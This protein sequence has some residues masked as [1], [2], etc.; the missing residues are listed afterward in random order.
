MSLPNNGTI[1]PSLPDFKIVPHS[2][3]ILCGPH[4]SESSKF[5]EFVSELSLFQN[6]SSKVIGSDILRRNLVDAGGIYV[7]YASSYLGESK[8]QSMLSVSAQAFE[9]LFAELKAY[10]SYPVNTD[11]VVIDTTGMDEGFRKQVVEVGNRAGY[12]N[13]LVTFEYKTRADYATING[14]SPTT[15]KGKDDIFYSVTRFRQKVLPSLNLKMFNERIRIKSK[16]SFLQFLHNDTPTFEGAP[17]PSEETLLLSQ[18][19]FADGT[20]GTSIFAV[21]GDSHECVEELAQLIIQIEARYEYI[22]I[23]HIGDYLDKGGNTKGMVEFIHDRYCK[24]DLFIEGNHERYVANALTNAS[25]KSSMDP[26]VEA[27]YFSSLSVLK[28]D[29]ELANKFLQVY[30]ASLPFLIISPVENVGNNPVILTHAPCKNIALG[31][32]HSWALRDQRNYRIEDRSVPIYEELSWLYDEA[33][34]HHPIHIFGHVSHKITNKYKGYSF[35]NKVFLDTGAVHGGMLTAVIINDCVIEDF[36]SV[37]CQERV[38]VTLPENL[39][40]RVKPIREFNIQDYDLEPKDL[41]LLGNIT[42]NNVRY[43]SGTMSPSQAFG[44]ELEPLKSALD[45]YRSKGVEHVSVQP[46]YMGSRC[47]MYLFADDPNKTFA[48]SRGG[49]K[50]KGVEGLDEEGYRGFLNQVWEKHQASVQESGELI[51]DGELLPWHALGKGL[52]EKDF[53]PYGTCIKHELQALVADPYFLELTDFV[54]KFQPEQRLVEITQFEEV[55]SWY[56]QPAPPEFKPFDILWAK[57]GPWS[58]NVKIASTVFGGFNSDVVQSVSLEEMGDN[59]EFLEEFFKNITV[60]QKMEGVVVKPL[61]PKP[62]VAPYLKVRSPEYLRLVYGYDYMMEPKYSRLLSQKNTWGKISLS[63]K[64]HE[65]GQQM[66][67]ASPEEMTPLV[68]KMI[69]H[70]KEEAFLD[71]RL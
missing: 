71:P 37:P 15:Q 22:C 31:K 69:G 29:P 19:F 23:I 43:I 24:G 33:N 63:L 10:T 50:I 34:F 21:I 57:E 65:L 7:D 45:Y 42:N 1:I 11:V 18:S 9:L 46:K 13:V 40:I 51:L 36:L 59:P 14:V 38:A 26:V 55:L 64:E 39:G 5:G 44:G 4:G 47:Q 17:L 32:T 66:L 41:R 49:W 30:R 27:E 20:L 62:G 60:E 48:V 68:V 52:I 56:A 67:V 58:E 2:I 53:T 61:T 70:F 6:L 35:K 3:Y 12:R 25:W 28:Q 8:S 16:D 54:A